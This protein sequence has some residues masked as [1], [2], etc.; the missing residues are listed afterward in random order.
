MSGEGQPP[1]DGPHMGAMRVIPHSHSHSPLP[2]PRSPLA[3]RDPVTLV[4]V[5]VLLLVVAILA[6][7]IPARRAMRV[8]PVIALSA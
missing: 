1:A 5:G 2:T 7:Y 4:A 6:M 3:A 8:S